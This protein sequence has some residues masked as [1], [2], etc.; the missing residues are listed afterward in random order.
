LRPTR[1]A[2]QPEP[3]APKSRIHSVMLNTN[4][5]SVSGT[6][7][8]CEIGTM[9]SRNIVKSNASSVQPSHAAHHARH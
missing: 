4:A 2:T 3:T 7:K 8:A 6:W 1:S 5:T 9:I